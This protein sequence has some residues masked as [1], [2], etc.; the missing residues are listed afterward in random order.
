MARK[1]QLKYGGRELSIAL[2]DSLDWRLCAPKDAPATGDLRAA[3]AA[4]L[5]APVASPA[6]REAATGGKKI[7]IVVCDETRLMR[8]RDFLPHLLDYL[9]SCGVADSSMDILVAY[10]SHPR[11]SDEAARELLGAEVCSRLRVH[12]HDCRDE[13]GLVWLGETSQGVPVKVN[14][15]VVE[16]DM[17]ITAGGAMHHYFAGFGGGRKMIVPGCAGFDTILA[18]HR[19]TL[20]PEKG[21]CLHPN[22]ES[23]VLDGNPVHEAALEAARMVGEV[24]TLNVVLNPEGE[25]AHFVSGELDAAHRCACELVDKIYA[26]DLP[27]RVGLVVAS[28]GGHPCDIDLIQMHKGVHHAARSLRDGGDLIICG[29]ATNGTGSPTF[30]HWFDYP[31]LEAMAAAIR[32]DYTLNAHTAY[33]MRQKAERIRISLLSSLD[34]SFVHKMGITPVES[35]QKTIDEAASSL[36]AG[37]TALI[38]PQANQTLQKLK[39]D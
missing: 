1:I 9:N 5:E 13:A 17:V 20:N 6:L 28:C 24:F 34:V 27:G 29:K 19:L 16:S 39:Q 8:T 14:R 35:L 18:N 4:S 21:A 36:G 10:G 2:P 33:A 37:S 12:H 31:G 30:A 22:C 7:T 38:I 25:V 26:V 15:I 23:G 32:E 11:I 3:L